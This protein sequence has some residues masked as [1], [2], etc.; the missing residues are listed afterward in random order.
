MSAIDLL[1]DATKLKLTGITYTYDPE[2]PTAP[3]PD[4]R[5]P[6][7]FC[8]DKAAGELAFD[9]PVDHF[10]ADFPFMVTYRF[11]ETLGVDASGRAL[12]RF[13]ADQRVDRV[14]P[15]QG[16]SVHVD[17]AD[18]N[19]TV[20]IA[21]ID[22]FDP[23]YDGADCA[24]AP[25]EQ[26]VRLVTA[27]SDVPNDLHIAA[28]LDDLFGVT[29]DTYAR[30]ISFTAL[31]G[32]PPPAQ[33]EALHLTS[34]ASASH[35]SCTTGR[36]TVTGFVRLSRP[37]VRADVAS[38]GSHAVSIEIA[39]QGPSGAA[40]RVSPASVTL[41]LGQQDAAFQVYLPADFTGL[42][43]VAAAAFGERVTTEIDV[44]RP[45]RWTC[46]RPPSYYLYRSLLGECLACR[47]LDIDTRG[48]P[49]LVRDGLV[50][51][52]LDGVVETLAE[53]PAGAVQA[54]RVN[55]FGD[56][57]GTRWNAQ[58]RPVGFLLTR[59]AAG[60]RALRE[61]EGASLLA[62]D[63]HGNAVGFRFSGG[64]RRGLALIKGHPTTLGTLGGKTSLARGI[65]PNGE[66]VGR[67]ATAKGVEH[68]FVLRGAAMEDLGGLGGA[69]AEAVAINAAGTVAGWGTTKD[70]RRAAFVRFPDKGAKLVTPRLLDGCT[71]SVAADL[72]DA[73]VAVGTCFGAPGKGGFTSRGVRLTGEGDTLALDDLLDPEARKRV[74]ILAAL[75][76][77][78]AG[79]ILALAYD[80]ERVA[81]ALLVP[82]G[83]HDK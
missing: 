56:V 28:H 34:V 53:L 80:G 44:E 75:R 49:V 5:A 82:A 26:T 65:G 8:I 11:T 35:F 36:S 24:G 6:D 38:S 48:Y 46:L 13:V 45:P 3:P 76:I 9:L 63:D 51:R 60:T 40:L 25:L 42:L 32:E 7:D 58:G 43:R 41:G 17:R 18:G 47:L 57:A 21:A 50:R 77:T 29:G 54:L 55:A 1:R 14:F 67:A 22:L 33:P 62:L 12:L 73:G 10:S 64:L 4:L 79:A 59:D 39:A 27:A 70:G 20:A 19:L 72:N 78:S 74:T 37:V 16:H 61:V 15:S 66:I 83:G 2:Y 31:A 68:A 30:A 52:E 71:E 81:P 23:A 69:V